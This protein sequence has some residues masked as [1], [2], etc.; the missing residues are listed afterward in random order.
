[1]LVEDENQKDRVALG[2]NEAGQSE[3]LLNDGAGKPRARLR[4]NRDGTTK[5]EMID[6]K[7]QATSIIPEQKKKSKR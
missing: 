4:V 5:L 3:L 2:L 1:M 6:E 7:G